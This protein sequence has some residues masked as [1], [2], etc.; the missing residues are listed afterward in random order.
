MTVSYVYKSTGEAVAT[1]E[2]KANIEHLGG[3]VTATEV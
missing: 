1:N 2:I 3:N